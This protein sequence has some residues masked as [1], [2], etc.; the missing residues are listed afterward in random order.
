MLR[1]HNRLR[2]RVRTCRQRNPRNDPRTVKIQGMTNYRIGP[3]LTLILTLTPNPNY[4]SLN[5]NF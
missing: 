1:T 2:I 3:R 4:P 5:P